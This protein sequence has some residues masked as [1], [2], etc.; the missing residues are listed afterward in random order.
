MDERKRVNTGRFREITQELNSLNSEYMKKQES[1]RKNPDYSSEFKGR[2]LTEIEQEY[3]K[4]AEELRKE[5]KKV[6][7]TMKSREE[8]QVPLDDTKLFNALRLLELYGQDIDRGILKGIIGNFTGRQASLQVI[9]GALEK[10]GI[11]TGYAEAHMYS[12]D[13][14]YNDLYTMFSANCKG[15]KPI[16]N[17]LELAA[18]IDELESK[19][20]KAENIVEIA[21]IT[22]P[23]QVF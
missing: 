17:E 13:D 18:V 14:T 22:T 2:R 3:L 23:V 7:E 1:L 9:A 11:S 16:K 12:V 4:K 5:G 19:N 10:H 21:E 8:T 15:L 20:N 6:L